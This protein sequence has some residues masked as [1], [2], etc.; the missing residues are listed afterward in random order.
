MSGTR[1]ACKT[2]QVF[3]FLKKFFHLFTYLFNFVLCSILSFPSHPSFWH[4][5]PSPSS[6]PTDSSQQVR[7][8][9]QLLLRSTCLIP[10]HTS[11]NIL[12]ITG[13]SW[14]SPNGWVDCPFPEVLRLLEE[15]S[16]NITN[17]RNKTFAPPLSPFYDFHFV[18]NIQIYHLYKWRQD[19]WPRIAPQG[20][21]DELTSDRT[22]CPCR[23]PRLPPQHLHHHSSQ[24]LVTLPPG[25]WAHFGL[26]GFF[27]CTWYTWTHIHM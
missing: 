21:E 12:S 7:A 18:P 19:T 24:L 3:F 26:C 20:L 16:R 1:N 2:K 11:W 22:Y 8:L 6:P 23:G 13:L 25:A 17:E 4:P 15:C 10:L 27:A 14:K 9:K 5:S